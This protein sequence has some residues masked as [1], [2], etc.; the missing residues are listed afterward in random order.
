M[1]MVTMMVRT[2]MMKMSLTPEDRETGAG[3]REGAGRFQS[4]SGTNC[5]RCGLQ[6]IFDIPFISYLQFV[7][8]NIARIA[9]AVQC[10]VTNVAMNSGSLL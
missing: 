7:T 6:I 5:Q 8:I 9:N 3:G 1:A 4:P 10:H 2:K